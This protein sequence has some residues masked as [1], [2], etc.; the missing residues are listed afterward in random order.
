[1]VITKRASCGIHKN[2]K[3]P[4]PT[5]P[6]GFFD[7]SRSRLAASHCARDDNHEKYF[8]A[9]LCHNGQSCFELSAHTSSQCGIPL[10]FKMAENLMF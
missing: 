9:I 2:L 3:L 10:A 7:S 5:A 8:T 4:T 6:P 1:M